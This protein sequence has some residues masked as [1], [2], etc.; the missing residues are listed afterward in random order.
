VTGKEAQRADAATPEPTGRRSP[1]LERAIAQLAPLLRPRGLDALFA[2]A[3]RYT[4]ETATTLEGTDE[5]FIVTGDIPAMWLRDACG[6]VLPYLRWCAG[7][8]LLRR[9]V[10]G[11]V[12][13]QARSIRRDP[14][15]NAF[16]RDP[17]GHSGHRLDETEH[18]PGVWE[19]KWEVDSL[20][21]ALRLLR[22]Y[23]AAASD[24]AI[25]AE[26]DVR[27][28]LGAILDTFEI[29]RDHAARSAYR[30]RRPLDGLLHHD[31][32]AAAPTA[33]TAPTGMIWGA[34]R[35]SD[36]GC[37][38]H[39]HLPS[40]M[41]AAVELR[42]LAQT[43]AEVYRAPR[44]AERA[45]TLAAGIE[46]GIERYGVVDHPQAGRI[47]AYEVDGLGHH[48][49]LD[50]AN[51]PSLLGIPE[52]GYR[53]ASDAVYQNTRRF[54]LS[55]AN[56]YYYRGTEATGIGSPHTPAPNVWPLALAVQALTSTD[57][58]EIERLI[59]TLGATDGG[60]G[61]IHESFDP[62]DPARFTRAEFGWA[63]ALFAEL[64][65]RAYYD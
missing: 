3:L 28:A 16:T 1:A 32:C 61:L 52:A 38:L 23:V 17:N 47:Y 63:N 41:L 24:R 12:L 13:R 59:A 4:L 49:L 64:I 50:D 45:D 46:A 5:T 58:G 29:E 43:F 19:R 35:P 21:W 40:Q 57:R 8:A 7:D 15:A 33:P 9:V 14:Y 22:L 55:A 65:L 37:E 11:L 30:F 6:Q 27:L 44:W 54:V 10:R 53:P 34:F 31:T 20:G 18:H 42:A 36:D 2:N 60:R 39:Y 48:R 62:T 56:P 51:L 26:L 25:Y